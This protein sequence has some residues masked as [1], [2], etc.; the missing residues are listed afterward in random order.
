LLDRRGWRVVQ[1]LVRT[2]RVHRSDRCVEIVGVEELAEPPV[3]LASY[4][5]GV[6]Y[7]LWFAVMQMR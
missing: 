7:W 6:D 5:G 2:N 3:Q 4:G 1:G